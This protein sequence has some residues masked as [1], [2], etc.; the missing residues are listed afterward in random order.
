M[1]HARRTETPAVAA[2]QEG[3]TA[4]ADVQVTR[5][6][7]VAVADGRS[8]LPGGMM[9]ALRSSRLSL[10]SRLVNAA[11]AI[12]LAR[13]GLVDVLVL[14]LGT[15]PGGDIRLV[16]S[17]A[18]NHAA[19]K[20]VVVSRS[21]NAQRVVHMMHAGA[22]GYLPENATGEDFIRAIES[23]YR[24]HTYIPADLHARVM[25]L[26]GGRRS[27]AAGVC[28]RPGLTDRELQVL[29]CIN[30]GAS[31]RDIAK[32]LGLSSKTVKNYL[33]NILS[34]LDAHSRVE[35][36][37]KS[38]ALS[39]QAAPGGQVVVQ[40]RAA[41][42]F[43][44][45]QI[46]DLAARGLRNQEI[47]VRLNLSV[48]TVKHY[49]GQVLQKWGVKNR[50]EAVVLSGKAALPAQRQGERR[51]TFPRRMAEM[52]ARTGFDLHKALQP[53]NYPVLAAAVGACARCGNAP[54]CHEWV[55]NHHCGTDN[56]PPDFC[57]IADFIR[58]HRAQARPPGGRLCE[59]GY[60]S[61]LQR[62]DV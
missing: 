39:S 14:N 36:M 20:I 34:K 62:P 27:H 3:A 4:T 57:R 6:T 52:L 5:P 48:A 33:T 28:Q 1:K 49:M 11:E 59:P 19:P 22:R 17:I 30:R 60:E 47:A 56:Q 15:M 24:G 41:L 35:V 37:L 10:V 40:Q 45:Q 43:R 53:D 50:L 16:E 32:A 7:R 44:E 2:P 21:D 29:D 42:S 23:V 8:V 61:G 18:R 54:K 55:A 12:V 51:L 26:M 9:Q 25:A 46:I 13:S 31:N 38:Q 58:S